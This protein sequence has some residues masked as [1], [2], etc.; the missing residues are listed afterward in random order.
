MN[1]NSQHSRH[2]NVTQLK[3]SSKKKQSKINQSIQTCFLFRRQQFE[4]WLSSSNRICFFLLGITYF[5]KYITN[6]WKSFSFIHPEELASPFESV[7]LFKNGLVDTWENKE[8]RD[9]F[10]EKQYSTC[11]YHQRLFL[12][13]IVQQMLFLLSRTTSHHSIRNVYRFGTVR[14]CCIGQVDQIVNQSLYKLV[15]QPQTTL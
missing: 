3:N 1:L 12:Q 4:S 13:N 2:F 11:D 9:H 6:F 15:N 8:R 14:Q 7:N 5:T 10:T